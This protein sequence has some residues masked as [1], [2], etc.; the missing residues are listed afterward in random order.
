LPSTATA[1]EGRKNQ[2]RPTSNRN[3]EEQIR[4]QTEGGQQ[5]HHLEKMKVRR[6]RTPTQ[7]SRTPPTALERST[8]E[9]KEGW[10]RIIP[11]QRQHLR[12]IN[13]AQKSTPRRI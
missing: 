5:Q 7:I 11:P 10:R 9:T 13:V 4:I 8:A 1:A 12:L 6:P 2:I 3:T